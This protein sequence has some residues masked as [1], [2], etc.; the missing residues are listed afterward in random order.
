MPKSNKQILIKPID[1]DNLQIKKCL[2]GKIAVYSRDRRFK[3][4]AKIYLCPDSR[5]NDEMETECELYKIVIRKRHVIGFCLLYKE[6]DY[7]KVPLM[8]STD[9]HYRVGH[10]LSQIM[11]DRMFDMNCSGIE[12]IAS[13][14]SILHHY[15]NGY[16]PYDQKQINAASCDYALAQ[17]NMK[18]VL[19]LGCLPMYLPEHELT[20]KYAS[21]ST[22]ILNYEKIADGSCRVGKVNLYNHHT[23]RQETMFVFRN[24]CDIEAETYTICRPA[25]KGCK[26]VILG[27]IVLN[28]FYWKDGKFISNFGSYPEWSVFSWYGKERFIDKTFAEYWSVTNSDCYDDNDIVQRLFQ[29]A[30][31]AGRFY[32]C[33]RLQIEADWDEHLSMY[34]YGFRTQPFNSPKNANEICNIIEEEAQQ[35]A[36]VNLNKLGSIEMYLNKENAERHHHSRVLYQKC[37]VNRSKQRSLHKRRR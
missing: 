21:F 34:D 29:I 1:I 17:N 14:N 22:P 35:K 12:L 15:R 2:A 33:P 25:C 16:R 7:I 30:L 13:W 5:F 11:I 32:D 23:R 37:R 8:G 24:D 3:T 28:Y 10:I 18:E 31:E 4:T 27:E 19:K 20:E 26:K 36:S 6:D 9:P